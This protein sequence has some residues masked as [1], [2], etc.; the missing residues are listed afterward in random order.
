MAT[1]SN[2]N[3]HLF[4]N[5]DPLGN[6]T[7]PFLNDID[8]MH[9]ALSCQTL[10][11]YITKNIDFE[12]RRR[13]HE[14]GIIF[15]PFSRLS[16]FEQY[17]QEHSLEKRAVKVYNKVFEN[18]Q[19]FLRSMATIDN[20]E[21]TANLVFHLPIVIGLLGGLGWAVAFHD[22][23]DPRVARHSVIAGTVTYGFSAAGELLTAFT[24]LPLKAWATAGASLFKVGQSAKRIFRSI[25][26]DRF[27]CPK[28]CK[29]IKIKAIDRQSVARFLFG[30]M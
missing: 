18:G 26:N 25:S 30:K 15:D 9:M 6:V 21:A 19:H 12:W 4:P 29:V 10:H 5:M 22:V 14:Q 27:F 2:L 23:E 17:A 16:I 11:K 24:D 3:Q 1:I 7:V 28:K 8:V 13:A 20:L